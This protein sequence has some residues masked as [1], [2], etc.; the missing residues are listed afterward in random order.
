LTFREEPGLRIVQGGPLDKRSA[1]ASEVLKIATG[2]YRMYYAGYSAPNRAQ[3]LTALSDDGLTWR[4]EPEPVIV[5]TEGG[6][7]G[8]K[9]SEMCVLQL[10]GRGGKARLRIFYEAC[11]GTAKDQRGVWRILSAVAEPKLP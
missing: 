11:D 9:C 6:L 10:P 2:G 5:P 8:V 7:D 3:I 4:K 1:F